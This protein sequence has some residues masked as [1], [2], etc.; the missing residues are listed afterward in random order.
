MAKRTYF[1]SHLEYTFDTGKY[2]LQGNFHISV[3]FIG[4]FS[5]QGAFLHKV[6]HTF[7]D[8]SFRNDI[9]TLVRNCFF[10]TSEDHM[11]L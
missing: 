2:H 9:R 3:T 8:K 10:N 6:C 1:A 7:H 11:S 4:L 5:F